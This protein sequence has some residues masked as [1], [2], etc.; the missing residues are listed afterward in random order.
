MKSAINIETASFPTRRH[1]RQVLFTLGVLAFC[2]A[3]NAVVPAPDGGYPGYNTAEGQNALFSLTTGVYNTALGA[4]SLFSGTT[5]TGNTAVGINDLRNNVTG[6]FNTAVGL[7]ALYANHADDNSAFGSHAL[8]ANTIGIVNSA[9]GWA[10]LASNTQGSGNTGIGVQALSRN[11]T[12]IGNTAT[13]RSALAFSAGDFNTAIG[14]S[15]GSNVTT[16]SNV[17]CIGAEV[18]G[19]DVSDSCY[20]GNIFNQTSFNGMPV[21]INGDNKLGTT[22]SSKRFKEDIKPMDHGSEAL[23]SLKPVTFHYKKEIDPQ[24]ASQFG[25]VAEEVE[26]V[27]PDLVVHD[28]EG[29]PYSVRYDQ[30]NAMLLNEFL[31]EYRKVQQQQATIGKLKSTVA[32]QQKGMEA[33][34]ARLNQQAAQIQK[35]SAE[36]ELNRPAAQMVLSNP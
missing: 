6:S 22:T 29:K 32:H 14:Y 16:A 34:T 21:L 26:K 24:G 8:F 5:G 13:G 2:Q 36:I 27:N 7:N 12:G 20:I 25:L 1:C 19:A 3:A 9:F 23:F 31:K 18:A 11:V 10:A 15:A 33:I 30:V 17:I 35:V 28:K 4:F